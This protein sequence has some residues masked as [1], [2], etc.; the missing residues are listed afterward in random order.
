[1]LQPGLDVYL[2]GQMSRLMHGIKKEFRYNLIY[3]P[4]SRLVLAEILLLIFF[5]VLLS[6]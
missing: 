6:L 5:T 2:A 1:L 4:N 3:L